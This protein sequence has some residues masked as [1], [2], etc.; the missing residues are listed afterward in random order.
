MQI[1][2]GYQ[3]IYLAAIIWGTLGVFARFS[4]MPP[5]ELSFYRLLIASVILSL[6]LP[7]EQRLAIGSLREYA[8]IFFAGFLFA[9]DCLFYFHALNITTF[10]NTVFPYNLQPVFMALI[11]PFFSEKREQG[12]AWHTLWALAGLVLIMLPSLYNLSW[13]DL[14]GISFAVAGTFCL[15][16]IAFLAKM[17]TVSAV[18]FVYYEV[19]IAT[20]CLVPFVSLSTSFGVQSYMWVAIIGLLH[21]AFAYMLYYDA[22]KVVK[23]QHAIAIVYLSPVVAALLGRLFFGEQLSLCTVLGGVLITV[24]GVTAVLKNN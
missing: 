7:R 9:V 6:L 10:S 11:A 16:I 5:V 15:S 2:S 4:G 24:N 17:V 14:M 3:Q 1:K 8:I 21:T 19:V 22:L 13:S 12:T 23:I 20:L 18:T